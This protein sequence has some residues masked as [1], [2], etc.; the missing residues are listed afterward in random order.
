M[1]GA[2]RDHPGFRGNLR[3]VDRKVRRR[4]PYGHRGPRP[5]PS[6]NL[7]PCRA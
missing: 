4:E 7:P 5:R 1:P 2:G 3:E 6:A